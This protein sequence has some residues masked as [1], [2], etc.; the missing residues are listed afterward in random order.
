[1]DG[2]ADFSGPALE[3]IQSGELTRD[4]TILDSSS[5]NTGI[6]YA[7]VAAALGY[8]L[9]LVMPENASEKKRI[10]EA[11]GAQVVFTDPLEGSDGA[12]LEA[13]RIFEENP[14]KYYL[15]DQYNNPNNWKAHYETTAEEIWDQTG[16]RLTHFVA[17]IGTSGTLMGNARRL[18]ELNPKI[19]IIAVEP[20]GALHGLEGLKHME[21]S[22]LPG[23]YDPSLHDRKISI[24]TEDS[25]EM[26]CR[27]ARQEG[28]LCG[29]SSGAA[30]QA[31]YQIANEIK[32]G[33]IVTVF[34]DG[35]DRYLRTQFWE[36]VL[37][38]WG[39]H[40]TEA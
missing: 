13:R 16:G 5:G 11:L 4:K 17:G 1:V 40:W 21:S 25:Y 33:L 23:I 2:A 7:I 9:E 27:L 35:G 10:I 28:M 8:R 30:L 36:E 12:I 6:G 39:E 38:Y 20:A 31:S 34:P 22:I 32:E 19:G 26:T 18:R 3:A 24:F 15:P 29:Y 14:G 37:K